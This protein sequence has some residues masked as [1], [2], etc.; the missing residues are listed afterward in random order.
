MGAYERQTLASDLAV[1]EGIAFIDANNNGEIDLGEGRLQ[2]VLVS[3]YLDDVTPNGQVDPGETLVGTFTTGPD[4]TYRFENLDGADDDVPSTAFATDDGLY[5]LSFTAGVGGVQDTTGVPLAGERL[6]SDTGVLISDDT[7]LQVA[8]IDDFSVGQSDL[9]A[10]LTGPFIG[11]GRNSPALNS[12]GT[13]I[14]DSRGLDF[15]RLTTPGTASFNVAGGVAALTGTGGSEHR[16]ELLYDGVDASFGIVPNGLGG[17]DLSNNVVA[18]LLLQVQSDVLISGGLQVDIFTDATNSSSIVVDI[19]NTLGAFSTIFLPFAS[20]NDVNGSGADYSNV[21]AVRVNLNTTGVPDAN[22]QIDVIESRKVNVF[23]ALAPAVADPVIGVVV[24]TLNDELDYSNDDVSLR[25]AINSANGSIGV[26]TITFAADLFTGGPASIELALGEL[27]I[28]DS[29]TITGPGQDLLAIDANQQSRVVNVIGGT[30]IDVTLEGLTIT[31]GRTTIDNQRVNSVRETTHSGG[32]IRFDSTGTLTLTGSTVS[33]NSTAG[34]G[35]NGGGI[36]T[37]S[38]TL[39]LTNT[40]VSG[41]S[42]AGLGANGGGIS[43]PSGTVTLIGSTVSGNSTTGDR[44]SG[45]GIYVYY[46][47]TLTLTDSTVSGNSTEGRSADGGGIATYDSAVTLTGSTVSGNST[48]GERAYGGGISASTGTVTLTGSTVSGNS[49]AG[50]NAHGGGLITRRGNVTL[51]NSTLSGNSSTGRGGGISIEPLGFLA[52]ASLTSHNS[53]IAGNTDAD[54]PDSAPDFLSPT[55]PANLD[56][57]SSLIGDSTGTTLTAAATADSSGNLVGTSTDPIDPLLAP[58]TLNGGPTQ[59]HALLPGSP[60]IDAGDNALVPADIETDQRGPGFARILGDR[61]DIGAFEQRSITSTNLVASVNPAIFGQPITFA[62]TV[63]TT[64][65]PDV[66]TGTVTFTVDGVSQPPV[67]LANGQASFT[68]SSLGVGSHSIVVVYSGNST[69]LPSTSATVSI[70][71]VVA[72][73]FGDAPAPYPVA[74]ANN[75]AR[76]TTGD[77]FLGASVDAEADGT[78]SVN[79][80]SDDGDDGVFVIS[81]FITT[82]VATTSSFSVTASQAGKLDGWIDFNN[83]GDWS[84]AGEQIFNSVDVVAGENLLSFTIPAGATSGSTGA[85]FRLSSAGGLAPTG[86]AADGEVEDYIAEIVSGSATAVLSIDV[87]GGIMNVVVQGGDLVARQGTT[88]L[89]RVPLARFGE[90][91]LNGSSIDD[92]LQLTILEAV[93]TK[94][95]LIDGGLGK[96]FLELVESGQTIDLTNA[97]I[98]VREIEGIDI[99]GTGDNTLVISIDSVKAVSSTT[100]TLQVISDAGD[101]IN[102]GDG[103]QAEQPRF[104]DGQFTHVI[105]EAAAGGTAR[106]EVQ[107]G[108]FFQNPL[109][110]FDVD[111]SGRIEPLD[112]LNVLITLQQL[113][114]LGMSDLRIPTNDAEITTFYPDVSGDNQVEPLDA[115]LVLIAISR[116]NRGEAPEGELLAPPMENS[117]LQLTQQSERELVDI[118]IMEF[119]SIDRIATFGLAGQPRV[120]EFDIDDWMQKLGA[121]NFVEGSEQSSGLVSKVAARF[122]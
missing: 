2:N 53:I 55:L 15:N 67:S 46:N 37:S 14:G 74:L 77:L 65:S 66:P 26:D 25:E 6:S 22:I 13:I 59:T 58:L 113:R 19:P 27:Q 120:P 115:L 50:D 119:E 95:L 83:D 107:N 75:G 121:E 40:T 79:A 116:I 11:I 117:S 30:K 84:D 80:D 33:G 86:A 32:G 68:T 18:G 45:G 61:V 94:T 41:N 17:V 10:T 28:S 111:R 1:I 98:T 31:G 21:G 51:K 44:A 82:N 64:E 122:P 56:V 23:T 9:P 16:L 76:H 39:T 101:T 109:S 106:V 118:A 114:Q 8:L 108:R 5:V 88:V 63:S 36:S 4:G 93:T 73:D 92:V 72:S 85:R 112:A 99:T 96:D 104:I 81:T 110:A 34:L 49:T 70:N 89:S 52:G 29:V 87:P 91:N 38:G 78:P 43:T 71:V 60:A 12:G 35:A 7:G 20:F 97:S 24:T 102:F 47:G 103:W 100:D 90:L 3:L 57:R 48:A 42:T 105:S 62:V 69:L 54:G